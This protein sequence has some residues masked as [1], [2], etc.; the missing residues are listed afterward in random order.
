MAKAIQ[1]KRIWQAAR[2]ALYK[3]SFL[4]ETIYQT[5]LPFPFPSWLVF[6]PILLIDLKTKKM[7]QT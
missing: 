2:T 3:L 6:S 4:I 1:T 5:R 7:V